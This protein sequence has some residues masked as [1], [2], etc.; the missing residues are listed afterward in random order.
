M[1][2]N[3]WYYVSRYG[4]DYFKTDSWEEFTGWLDKHLTKLDLFDYQTSDAEGCCSDPSC[5]CTPDYGFS[6]DEQDYL[7]DHYGLIV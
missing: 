1:P 5:D 7:E 4:D 2:R 3:K 6:P